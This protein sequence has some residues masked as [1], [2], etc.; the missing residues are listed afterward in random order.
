MD[1]R[2]STTVLG[3]SPAFP[4]LPSY[5]ISASASFVIVY[6]MTNERSVTREI[7]QGSVWTEGATRRRSEMETETRARRSCANAVDNYVKNERGRLCDARDAL[8][9]ETR[10]AGRASPAVVEPADAGGVLRLQSLALDDVNDAPKILTVSD[11]LGRNDSHRLGGV[12]QADQD[13]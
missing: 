8:E 7:P 2:T 12:D 1:G 10:D 4:S 6:F 3:F 11:F 9:R 5:W 13:G